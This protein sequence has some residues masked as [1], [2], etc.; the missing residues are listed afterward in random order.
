MLIDSL[1]REDLIK[2]IN[3]EFKIK[4]NGINYIGPSLSRLVGFEGLSDILESED[5]ALR[6]CR[7]AMRSPDDVFTRKLRRGLTLR[8]YTK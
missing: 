4:V 6:I 3:R 2:A 1:P 8:F 5:L 7:D